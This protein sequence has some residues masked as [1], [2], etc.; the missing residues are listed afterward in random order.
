MIRITSLNCQPTLA[1]ASIPRVISHHALPPFSL[2]FSPP[3]EHER[4]IAS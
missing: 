4:V 1:A 2:P 3:I